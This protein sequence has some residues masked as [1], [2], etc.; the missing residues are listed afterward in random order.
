LQY[1]NGEEKGERERERIRT[2]TINITLFVTQL[3]QVHE[4]LAIPNTFKT[5]G[6]NYHHPIPAPTYSSPPPLSFITANKISELVGNCAHFNSIYS[7]A[8]ANYHIATKSLL[9]S[10]TYSK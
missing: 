10:V 3:H 4:F 6:I 8:L 9:T 5:G 1:T 7:F 2:L